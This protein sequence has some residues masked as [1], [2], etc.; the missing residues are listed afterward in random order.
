VHEAAAVHGP[1]VVQGLLQRIE[2]EARMR[3]ARRTPSD[4][5]PRIG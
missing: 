5:A 3:R 4:D 2:H 1:P